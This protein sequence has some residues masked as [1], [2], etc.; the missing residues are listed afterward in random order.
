MLNIINVI[1]QISSTPHITTPAGFW[2]AMS[3]FIFVSVM[4]LW[5]NASAL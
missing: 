2:Y 1:L 4:G 3:Y 5:R